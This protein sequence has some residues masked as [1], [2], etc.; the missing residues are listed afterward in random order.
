MECKPKVFIFENVK[1]MLS[2]DKGRTWKV[3]KETFEN[4]CDYKV[5][6]QVL[7]GKDYGVPQSRDRLFCIG[8]K[9]NVEFKYPNSIP[10]EKSVFDYLETSFDKKYLLKQKGANFITRSI[11]HQKSYTQIN[12]NILLCQK[13]NQQFNWHGDFVF[14]SEEDT[15]ANNIPELEKYFLSENEL[16]LWFNKG[17]FTQH[18]TVRHQLEPLSFEYLEKI[19]IDDPGVDDIRYFENACRHLQNL[20]DEYSVDVPLEVRQCPLGCDC[21]KQY[22]SYKI[23]YI[24][25]KFRFK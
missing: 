21:Q 18:F 23:G 10:L 12:G 22:R 25:H 17:D 2:H 24:Y 7:N 20:M 1:G 6:F 8:F 19:I 4:D 11:N 3:I 14:Q 15:K 13:R 9:N 16:R 5:Y